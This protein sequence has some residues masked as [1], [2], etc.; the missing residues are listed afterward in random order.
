M[1]AP[2]RPKAS[3]PRSCRRFRDSKALG[4]SLR[5]AAVPRSPDCAMIP[6]SSRLKSLKD[7]TGHFIVFGLHL[8]FVGQGTGTIHQE[9]KNPQGGPR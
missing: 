8:F 9:N 2:E 6:R 1:R 3:T 5:P 4:V 7:N